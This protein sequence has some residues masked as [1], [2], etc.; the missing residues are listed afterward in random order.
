M[1]PAARA[2]SLLAACACCVLTPAFK[3]P[4]GTEPVAGPGRTAELLVW[5]V[6]LIGVRL[7]EK[8]RGGRVQLAC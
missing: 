7:C 8:R 6:A 5:L 2:R 4:R 3:S 1:V